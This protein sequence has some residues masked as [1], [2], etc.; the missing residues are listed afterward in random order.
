M[1]LQRL[2]PCAS[3]LSER[4]QLDAEVNEMAMLHQLA[5]EAIDLALVATIVVK[6]EVT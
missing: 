2:T 3:R 6:D 1:Y 5:C 4:P